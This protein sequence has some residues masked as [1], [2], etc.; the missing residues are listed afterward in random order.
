MPKLSVWMIRAA[1]VYLGVGFLFGALMLANK[2]I[3]YEPLVWRLLNP[4]FELLI[5]GWMIQLAMGVAFW[6][7]P[8]FSN[9]NRYGRENLGWVS[10]FLFN[11]GIL[12]TAV[13]DLAISSTAIMIGY[14]LSLCGVVAFV[15]MIWSRV[16]PLGG[17]AASR[18]SQG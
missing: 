18:N 5:Y 4:H 8:R 6:A 17:D 13:A 15:I 10:F 16:K 9:G 3:P 12:I 11:G 2:G 14:L 1:L 7:L